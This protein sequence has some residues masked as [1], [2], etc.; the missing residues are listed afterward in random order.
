MWWAA[1]AGAAASMYAANQQKKAAEKAAENQGAP[2]EGLQPHLTDG[3]APWWLQQGQQ[4]PSQEWS[5]Y[6]SGL[7]SGR[8]GMWNQTPPP[9][10]GAA[11][12]MDMAPWSPYAGYQQQF[13]LLT[14]LIPQRNYSI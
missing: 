10:Y 6:I 9:M 3:Q 7:N 5:D 13:A 8:G 1:L 4:A 2:W 14:C 12:S 11:P